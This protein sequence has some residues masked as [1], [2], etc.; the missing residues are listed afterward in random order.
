M[1]QNFG[2]WLTGS[3]KCWF[4]LTQSETWVLHQQ[5]CS[6]GISPPSK[7]NNS[8]PVQPGVYKKWGKKKKKWKSFSAGNLFVIY[9]ILVMYLKVRMPGWGSWVQVHGSASDCID[10][11]AAW[12][13]FSFNSQSYSKHWLGAWLCMGFFSVIYIYLI[14]KRQTRR[15]EKKNS[16]HLKVVKD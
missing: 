3:R 13:F 15:K 7:L 9:D 1:L 16:C 12:H 2:R 10:Q 11:F 14:K 5:T 4:L 6:C 8:F